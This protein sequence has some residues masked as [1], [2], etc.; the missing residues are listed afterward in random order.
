MAAHFLLGRKFPS[1]QV[2]QIATGWGRSLFNLTPGWSIQIHGSEHSQS[3]QSQPAV[4]VS[5]HE[6]ATDILA[7]YQLNMQFRWIAKQKIF[8]LPIIGTAMRAADYVG[9]ERGNKNSHQKALEDSRAVLRSGTNMLFF[10]EGTRST[11][12]APRK[13]KIGAFKLAIEEDLPIL[14]AI[15][16]GS[17]KLMRKGTLIPN[18]AT[19]DLHFL[20]PQKHRPNEDIT[21]YTAR[22]ERLIKK[23]H[24][25]LNALRDAEIISTSEL[26][27]GESEKD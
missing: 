4:I 20:P 7:F 15:L 14:P 16:I 21:D 17:G 23:K 27:L 12:G 22:I 1:N 3:P 26:S 13:F 9:V 10:P 18:K 6:S 5:N 19:I 2:H 25:E 24:S 11:T 8:S